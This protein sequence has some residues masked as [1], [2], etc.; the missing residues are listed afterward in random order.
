ME[1]SSQTSV[2]NP[3][4]ASRC[5]FRDCPRY[6]RVS[7]VSIWQANSFKL[8]SSTISF[9]SSSISNTII[10]H[11]ITSSSTIYNRRSINRPHHPPSKHYRSSNSCFHPSITTQRI[12]SSRSGSICKVSVWRRWYR[13]TANL[14]SVRLAVA[15][16]S[17][18]RQT[19]VPAVAMEAAAF[20]S[21]PPSTRSWRSCG[22]KCTVYDSWICRFY[23][24]CGP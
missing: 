13:S 20:G 6:R 8:T 10:S 18:Q 1:Y 3:D 5:P 7:V 21:Q 15:T 11:L 17:R 23:R 2:K 19:V 24:S 9:S 12:R 22:E 16:A 4:K 14:Q